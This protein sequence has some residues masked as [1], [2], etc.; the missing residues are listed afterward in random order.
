MGGTIAFAARVEGDPMNIASELA[1]IVRQVD[2]A[3]AIEGVMP[4]DDVLFGSTARPRF[5][6]MI[7]GVFGGIAGFLAAIGIYGVLAYTVAQRTQEFGIRLALG[8]KRSHVLRLVL[9]QGAVMIGI[10]ISAGIA[11]A[12]GLT[13]YLKAMLFGIAPLDALTYVAIVIIFACVT[14]LAA[15]IPA[16]R[17]TKV[18]PLVALR[19]E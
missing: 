17:A 13:R 1:A 3:A 4:M 16:R 14:L 7:V 10:G 5:Y 18:D 2:P 19:H 9:L 15:Y 12:A 6:A 8:A 11:G